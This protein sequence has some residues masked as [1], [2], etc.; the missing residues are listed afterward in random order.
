MKY[1]N[2]NLLCLHHKDDSSI[3]SFSKFNELYLFIFAR[4]PYAFLQASRPTAWPAKLSL[5]LRKS[6]IFAPI[7][8][9]RYFGPHSRG[10]PISVPNSGCSSAA[11]RY[12][13]SNLG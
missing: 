7:K 6:L 8:F 1:D 10:P 2:G 3:L 11:S 9:S 13:A 5:I 4:S 12:G